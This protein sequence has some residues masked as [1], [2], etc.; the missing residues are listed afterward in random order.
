LW[1]ESL[2][3]RVLLGERGVTGGKGEEVEAIGEDEAVGK[4]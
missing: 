4:A 2:A 3:E 1:D